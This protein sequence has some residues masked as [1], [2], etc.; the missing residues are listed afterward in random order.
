MIPPD[1][2]SPPKDISY[3]YKSI[4]KE[5]SKDGYSDTLRTKC[6]IT[7]QRA[8]FTCWDGDRRAMS[9][10]GIKKNNWPQSPFACEV[11][12][13]RVYFQSN[14]FGPMLEVTNVMMMAE[15]ESCPFEDIDD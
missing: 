14:R 2:L 15:G 1:T 7:E 5:A 4:K 10:S 13:K 12:L 9:T 11:A 6:T 3:W 8:S